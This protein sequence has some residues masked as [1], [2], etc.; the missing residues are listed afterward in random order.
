MDQLTLKYNAH[1]NQLRI[2]FESINIKLQSADLNQHRFYN[3][4]SAWAS[5]C[6]ADVCEWAVRLEVLFDQN[7]SA[8]WCP[9][10]LIPLS[11]SVSVSMILIVWGVLW[12]HFQVLRAGDRENVWRRRHGRCQRGTR[13]AFAG[14]QLHNIYYCNMIARDALGT[15]AYGFLAQSIVVLRIACPSGN[16]RSCRKCD[17]GYCCCYCCFR[18]CGRYYYYIYFF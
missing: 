9:Y 2:Q 8:V 5:K 7:W 14:R 18:C 11:T 13:V 12:P 3:C 6:N 10:L 1:L 16:V 17:R 4:R 15:L